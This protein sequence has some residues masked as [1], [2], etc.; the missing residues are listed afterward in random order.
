MTTNTFAENAQ[1]YWDA[2]QPVIPLRVRH[3]APV[4][5]GW[6]IFCSQMPDKDTQ[7][8][9]LRSFPDG[10]IGLP[11]GP[12]SGLVAIDVDTDDPKVLTLLERILPKSPWRRVGKKGYVVLYRSRPSDEHRTFR[13]K[14]RDGKSLVEF[15]AKGTQ[16]VLPP[17]IHP[18]TQKPYTA[19]AFLPDVLADLPY[20]SKDIETILRGGLSDEGI[21]LS[22]RGSAKM[23]E[24][25]AS[26]NRDSSL[27]S[28]CG[29][30]A[31]AVIRA[32]RT[33]NEAFGEIETWINNF[34]EKVAGDS[35]SPEKGRAKLVEFI[36]RD[37]HEGKRKLPMGWD[38]GLTEE[39]RVAA[40]KEFGEDHEEWTV[41]RCCD[42]IDGQFQVHDRNSMGRRKAVEDV[43][44]RMSKSATMTSLDKEQVLS[45]AQAM[46]G[47]TITMTT[48]RKRLAEL[49]RG[50][51]EGVDHTEIAQA[52][53]KDLS[54]FGEVRMDGDSFW[55]WKGSH[56][57]ALT[58][59][60]IMEHIA[61]EYGAMTAARRHNDHRGILKVAENLV[62]KGLRESS[63]IGINFANG[64][65]TADLTLHPHESKYGCT[66]VLPYCYDAALSAAPQRF[67]SFLYQ[68][69]GEDEDYDDKVLALREAIAVTMFQQAWKFQ[70][71]F[72]LL[73][74]PESGKS[75][76]KNIVLGL[77]PDGSVCTVPP[78]DWTDKFLPTQMFGKLINYCGEL[79]E[80]Q[81]IAGD[82]FK[83]IIEGADISGQHKNRPIFQ[84]KTTCAQWFNS[85]HLPRTRDSSAGFTRR[86]L[87]LRFNKPVPRAE[88]IVGL[89]FE[90]LAEERDA[91][92]AWAV[93][94]M[95][96][97][98]ANNGYTEP[99]SSQELLGE[100][101]NSNNCVRTFLKTSGG[102]AF[103]QASRCAMTEIHSAYWA[104][105]KT[106]L[107]APPVSLAMFKSRMREMQG[108]FGFQIKIDRT[109]NGYDVGFYEGIRLLP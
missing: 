63:L 30:E 34:T 33:L 70:T 72:C 15:L 20:I 43:L 59:A 9:W 52:L 60:R 105:C 92:A 81:F 73:G 93:Q 71:A 14:D 94:V 58:E 21:E 66:H 80:N 109:E 90:I 10:N 1:K 98:M 91:I 18:D 101:A 67:F 97:L 38:E 106:V 22:T 39:E 82:R 49:E 19:N 83:S 64:Y 24:W 78:H 56:W 27:V 2:G 26:G 62:T 88:K 4:P 3:K 47:K 41:E 17:S 44:L 54:R 36:K 87:F 7:E 12:C 84:F 69:W 16:I 85:N 5:N 35:I 79:S 86:W 23:V 107:H 13:I 40:A 29:L 55:Q 61:R 50:E 104:F 74:I 48:M 45:H 51:I 25:V 57:E 77:M 103:V 46:S 32:E 96:A 53:I 6:Q 99:K 108:E 95:P 65:L 76:L 11:L 28:I 102:I 75:V 68:S 42:Y 31:R 8:A 89:D 37:I 100:M